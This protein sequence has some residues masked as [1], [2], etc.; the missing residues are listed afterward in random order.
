MA[1]T[2]VGFGRGRLFPQ[3]CI[4]LGL[5]LLAVSFLIPAQT[6][7]QATWD[8]GKAREFQEKAL[9]LHELAHEASHAE[10]HGGA[11]K[12]ERELA[13]AQE[14]FNAI[15]KELNSAVQRPRFLTQFFRWTGIAVASAGILAYFVVDNR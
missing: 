11:K 7:S 5:A 13:D 15:N 4:A 9:R 10:E 14:N 1:G 8:A 3:V 2:D 6:V 12:V